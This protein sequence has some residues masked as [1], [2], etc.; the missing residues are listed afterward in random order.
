MAAV[1]V[2]LAIREFFIWCYSQEIGK[3]FVVEK[4][5]QIHFKLPVPTSGP[6]GAAK[7]DAAGLWSKIKT[8]QGIV[9]G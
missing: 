5:R 1:A 9:G 4:L 8:H 2:N 3:L 7:L 6:A